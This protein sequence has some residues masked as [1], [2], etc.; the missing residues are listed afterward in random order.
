MLAPLPAA[1]AALM[2]RG[3]GS[4]A[5]ATSPMRLMRALRQ[6]NA[7]AAAAAATRGSD[8]GGCRHD[9]GD[10]HDDR[11]PIAATPRGVEEGVERMGAA[12]RSTNATAAKSPCHRGGAP[13]PASPM[14]SEVPKRRRLNTQQVAMVDVGVQCDLMMMEETGAAAAAPSVGSEPAGG[15]R[16]RTTLDQSTMASEQQHSQP[17]TTATAAA[18]FSTTGVDTS[19]CCPR[20]LAASR[21]FHDEQAARGVL[22]SQ[23]DDLRVGVFAVQAAA[24]R[25]KTSTT[26]NGHQRSLFAPDGPPS[27]SSGSSASIL[28]PSPP[29]NVAPLRGGSSSSAAPGWSAPPPTDKA[30]QV[31]LKWM[32]RLQQERQRSATTAA[33]SSSSATA[34]ARDAVL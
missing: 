20:C 2:T 28:S 13:D 22:Q 27:S 15:G 7:E 33:P 5:M 16:L 32:R 8:G 23:Y 14:S 4:M 9:D 21:I 26:R 19:S 10:A 24:V 18:R 1:A 34:T 30:F 6:K 11:S 17:T 12:S 25:S 31:G 29:A 3:D